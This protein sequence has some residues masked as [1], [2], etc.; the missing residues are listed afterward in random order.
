SSAAMLVGR[1]RH[2]TALGDALAV[3]RSGRAVTVYVHGA[4]GMGKSALV[5]RF[6]DG[7]SDDPR[8]V[9]LAGRCYERE[10]VPYKA[11]DS[12]VDALS[13]Y[14]MQLP[15]HE[16]HTLLPRHVLALARLFP[17]L[18]RVGAVAEAPRPAAEAPDPHEMRKRA[19]AALRELLARLADR[20]TPVVYIDDLQWGDAASAA[21]LADLMRPPDP[22]PLLLLCCY[23]SEDAETSPLLRELLAPEPQG[24]GMGGVDIRHVPVGPLLPGEA[25]DL[26]M[27]LLGRDAPVTR[28]LAERVARES[29]GSPFFVD[30]LVRHLQAGEELE[31]RTSSEREV[32]LEEVLR[33]RLLRLPPRAR[34]LLEVVAVAGRPIKQ[35]V[36]GAA[37]ELPAEDSQAMAIL[38]A[39]HLV[40]TRGTRDRD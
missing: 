39:G 7:L 11:L 9:V 15:V 29:G 3:A 19:F 8:T 38:R 17:V 22:P 10:S 21:L 2:L 13:R 24:D 16:A 26:A 33:A 32:S 5:Q 31:A 4:S 23:R 27:T 30:E 20:T 28:A 40:R 18:R 36:A 34:R 12:V 14:L 35:Q 37:A 1:E 25:C 6:L